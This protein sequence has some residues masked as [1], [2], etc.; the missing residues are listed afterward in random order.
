MK[1]TTI[2]HASLIRFA[3]LGSTPKPAFFGFRKTNQSLAKSKTMVVAMQ[4]KKI[5]PI[6]NRLIDSVNVVT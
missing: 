5:Q 1:R 3:I 2:N 4:L 6:E